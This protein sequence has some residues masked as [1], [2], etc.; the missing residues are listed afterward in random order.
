[1]FG[2]INKKI[3]ELFL[4]SPKQTQQPLELLPQDIFT[5]S[6]IF[7][8]NYLSRGD[9]LYV[10]D[11]YCDKIYADDRI[12]ILTPVKNGNSGDCE[13]FIHLEKVRA[14][15]VKIELIRKAPGQNEKESPSPTPKGDMRLLFLT[16]HLCKNG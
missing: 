6:I 13:M 8:T 1:M 10:E 4:P 2:W 9:V 5:Q 7:N 16:P 11:D 12:Y 14:E 15:K 3:D